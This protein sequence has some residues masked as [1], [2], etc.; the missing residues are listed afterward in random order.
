MNE[1]STIDT[2]PPM[3]STPWLAILI[4]AMSRATPNRMRRSPAQLM[5]RLW[6]AKKARIR[7]MPPITPGSTTPGFDSSK[8][9]PSMPTIMRI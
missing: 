1:P 9:M 7:E 6:K 4:S 8:K 3:V 5:G 2:T